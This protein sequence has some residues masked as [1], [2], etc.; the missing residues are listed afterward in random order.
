MGVVGYLFFTKYNYNFSGDSMK[1][2]K[3]F[4]AT[5]L[6]CSVVA[7]AET[8]VVVLETTET[9]ETQS[10]DTTAES[11]DFKEKEEVSC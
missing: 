5:L 8:E 9:V 3:F 2:M 11:T 4:V 10:N 7:H 1:L 6:V